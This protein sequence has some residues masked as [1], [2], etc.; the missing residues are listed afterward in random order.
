MAVPTH[1][2][3]ITVTGTYVDHL[4]VAQT[5]TV[6]FTPSAQL[7]DMPD[8]KVIV[9]NTQ[10]ATLD[11][12][13][14]F[15]IALLATDDPDVITRD[16]WVWNVVQNVTGN[17]ALQFSLALPMSTPGATFDMSRIVVSG[18]TAVLGWPIYSMQDLAVLGSWLF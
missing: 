11:G 2:S 6:T 5:G 16:G 8:S 4:G 13:G 10:T 7:Y 3:R 17:T 12:N 18:S 9:P 1:F 15:S 14:S